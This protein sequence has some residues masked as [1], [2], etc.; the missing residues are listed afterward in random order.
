MAYEIFI[1]SCSD[2]KINAVINVFV[3]ITLQG[4]VTEG[5]AVSSGVNAQP[6]GFA[7]TYR[8]ATNRLHAVEAEAKGRHPDYIVSL[9]NGLIPIGGNVVVDMAVVLL[10]DMHTKVIYTATSAGIPFP[11][12]AIATAKKRG[13]A[14][15]TVGSVLSE[16]EATCD[17]ADPHVFLCDGYVWRQDLLEGAVKIAFVQAFREAKKNK[18]Y[19]VPPF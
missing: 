13:F 19:P 17:D 7:E 4:S 3:G 9:E 5:F 8:G 2:I 1:A 18:S 15:T 14:T 12:D 11:N 6:F 10:K 16:Q